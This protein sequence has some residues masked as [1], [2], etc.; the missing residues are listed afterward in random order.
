MT[1]TIKTKDVFQ[2]AMEK[3]IIADPENARGIMAQ[4]GYSKKQIK[5]VIADTLEAHEAEQTK[6]ALQGLKKGFTDFLLENVAVY[7][8]VPDTV[9][10][11]EVRLCYTAKETKI[12]DDQIIPPG[13]YV[14]RFDA[15]IKASE[16]MV[17]LSKIGKSKGGGNGGSR[18]VPVPEGANFASWREHYDQEY[19]DVDD[20]TGKSAPVYLRRKKDEVYLAAEEAAN[21]AE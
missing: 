4:A 19:G 1:N 20:W 18:A 3:L 11:F 7:D 16:K 15:G 12:K 9:G 5:S 17:N 8:G 21:K 10:R 2:A 13:F 6:K 14:S